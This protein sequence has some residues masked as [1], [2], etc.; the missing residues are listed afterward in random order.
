MTS[1]SCIQVQVRGDLQRPS[2]VTSDK[3]RHLRSRSINQC[4]SMVLNFDIKK[5]YFES[6]NTLQMSDVTSKSAKVICM[7][8][9]VFPGLQS[10]A[11]VRL[12]NAFNVSVIQL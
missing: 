3:T 1:H 7:L 8:S 12:N 6:S 4:F 11:N 2:H 5:L 10:A 9:F